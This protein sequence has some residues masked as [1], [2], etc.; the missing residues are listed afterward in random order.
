MKQKAK[1]QLEK[2][3]NQEGRNF[4]DAI[5]VLETF[6]SSSSIVQPNLIKQGIECPAEL[7]SRPQLNKNFEDKWMD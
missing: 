5:T 1:S 4:H 6:I 3:Q 2:C 7:E